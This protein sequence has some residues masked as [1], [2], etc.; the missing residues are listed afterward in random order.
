MDRPSRLI[1]PAADHL[2]V[3]RRYSINCIGNKTNRIFKVMAITSSAFTLYNPL[4]GASL[5]IAVVAVAIA[6]QLKSDNWFSADDFDRMQNVGGIYM[7]LVGTLY[8][9]I[10]GM[11]MVDASG[12]F[13]DA[14]KY[15]EEESKAMLSMYFAAQQMPQEN[16]IAIRSS[17]R[18]YVE[19]MLS[20]ELQDMHDVESFK[21]SKALYNKVWDS[22]RAIEPVTENQKTIYAIL[23]DDLRNGQDNR[24]SRI[25]FSNFVISWIEWVCLISG[26]I[27]N[28]AFSFFFN[29]RNKRTHALMTGMVTFMVSINLYAIY[30]LSNPYSGYLEIPKDGFTFVSEA[31]KADTSK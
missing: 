30:M 8:S 22:V 18:N 14:K 29:I 5:I 16:I 25:A 3:T 23:M 2:G 13:S 4:I 26:G 20:T 15:V 31:I 28:I 7:S 10:L 21:K 9:V 1:T 11:I 12:N 27:I 24:R 17:I 6:I 19:Y